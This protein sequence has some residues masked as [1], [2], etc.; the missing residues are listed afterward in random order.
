MDLNQ[1]TLPCLDYDASVSFY[2]RLGFRQIVANPPG[3]ARF[4]TASGTTFS[5]HTVGAAAAHPDPVVY[6]EVDDVDA[7]VT[8]LKNRGIEFEHDPVDQEW[9]WREAYLRDPAGN[10]LCIYHAGKNRRHPPW[11]IQHPPA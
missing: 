11:R 4:E 6:F 5:V 2:R 3:Y 8:G 7:A 1:I 10:R 9:L